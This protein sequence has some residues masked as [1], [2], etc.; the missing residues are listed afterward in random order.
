LN[1]SDSSRPKLDIKEIK[2]FYIR[3][4]WVAGGEHV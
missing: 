3:P 1:N 2:L 4:L